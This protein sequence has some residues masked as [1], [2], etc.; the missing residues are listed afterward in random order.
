MNIQNKAFA[1]VLAVVLSIGLFAAAT[2]YAA[3]RVSTA[4]M[5]GIVLAGIAVVTCLAR[6]AHHAV[7]LANA[8]KV[9]EGELIRTVAGFTPTSAAVEA[10]PV[11]IEVASV[12]RS[13]PVVVPAMPTRRRYSGTMVSVASASS[14]TRGGTDSNVVKTGRVMNVKA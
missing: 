12:P 2:F 1:H 6:M 8:E 7:R 14:Y 11:S 13:V 9:V 10:C 5:A 4:V 3:P